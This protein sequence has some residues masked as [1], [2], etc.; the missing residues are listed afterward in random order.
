MSMFQKTL[1]VTVAIASVVTAVT[2]VPAAAIA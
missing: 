1:L 2:V